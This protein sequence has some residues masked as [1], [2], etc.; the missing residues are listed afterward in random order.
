MPDK[1]LK[2]ELRW[3]WLC[4]LITMVLVSMRN[5]Y[6]IVEFAG[7]QHSAIDE[8]QVPYMVLDLLLMLFT[9]TTFIVLDLGSDWVLPERIRRAAMLETAAHMHDKTAQGETE[10]GKVVTVE[11][12]DRSHDGE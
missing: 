1:G 6:R 10:K 8:T 4:M 12:T 3:A 5:I 9:G 7:G 11:M 2:R